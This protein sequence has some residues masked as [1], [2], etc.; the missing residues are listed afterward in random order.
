MY[1]L[2][3]CEAWPSNP[4]S[5]TISETAPNPPGNPRRCRF[6]RDLTRSIW[7]DGTCVDYEQ[8]LNAAVAR[9]RQV[10]RDS[11]ENPRYIETVARRGYRFVAPV[12]EIPD[13][14]MAGSR[15]TTSDLG[16][17]NKAPA[18]K[19]KPSSRLTAL[20][21]SLGV[22]A[23]ALLA[24][25]L[26]RFRPGSHDQTLYSALPLTSYR[27]SEFGPS[28]SPGGDRVA[29][30]W[31][32]EK[33]DNFDIYAKQIDVETPLRLTSDPKPD[34]S[35][36]WS[37]DGR[38]IA[39]VRMTSNDKADVLLTPSFAGGSERKIAE[40][41]APPEHLWRSRLVSW[42]S[43]SKWLVVPDGQAS[44]EP[45]GLTL[46]AVS[47]GEKRPLTRPLRE[48]DVDAAFAPD[49]TRLVFTRHSSQTSSDLYLLELSNNLVLRGEPVQL[50]FRHRQA[51]SPAWT[52]D[53]KSILFAR[54]PANGSPSLWR[55]RL[56]GG[57]R[58]EPLPVATESALGLAIS[59]KTNRLIYT[60]SIENETIWGLE[61]FGSPLWQNRKRA[62]RPWISSSSRD[63]TADFSPDGR[64]IA[65]QSVRSGY[66][67]V[68]VANRDGSQ[69]R[70]LT[71]LKGTI[72]LVAGCKKNCL[73]FAAAERSSTLRRRCRR[74][75]YPPSRR[76]V[77][78]RKCTTKLVA[79]WQVDL[80]FVPLVGKRPDLEGTGCRWIT[81]PHDKPRRMVAVRIG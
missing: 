40:L 11:A 43:D 24:L 12:T 49:M 4:P 17:S 3:N 14:E 7:R 62:A 67:E 73:P 56:S 36:A 55:M 41:A 65:F 9:L 32:G 8:G 13:L 53:G 74:R 50:E 70:Q 75:A 6:E 10:L 33:Q 16:P 35:P 26:F 61:A 15:D 39:F 54:Y 71:D 25:V 78:S 63:S 52:S 31:D 72:A 76:W 48:Y 81:A 38:S 19:S 64:Q 42:S 77:G 60:H 45:L 79:R 21:L 47:T 68:W 80:L 23:I 59:S 51:V 1:R 5:R 22:V 30:S 58:T 2:V 37:P 20:W 46:L 66:A 29:F 57:Q 69:P 28:F 27:G 44:A 18:I 34:V